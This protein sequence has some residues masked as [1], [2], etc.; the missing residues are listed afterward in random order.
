MSSGFA[1]LYGPLRRRD[2]WDIFSSSV[3]RLHFADIHGGGVSDRMERDGNE[4]VVLVVRIR[5]GWMFSFSFSEGREG[6]GGVTE[7]APTLLAPDLLVGVAHRRMH[8]LHAASS[9]V[10]IVTQRAQTFRAGGLSVGMAF[11][12]WHFRLREG[13]GCRAHSPVLSREGQKSMCILLWGGTARVLFLR[14]VVH[15]SVPS[16]AKSPAR[17]EEPVHLSVLICL[18]VFCRR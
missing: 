11:V 16:V 9:V 5:V 7:L 10:E 6:F 15:S 14:V 3:F 12:A 1:F 17:R 18:H 2:G 4:R 13:K 8:E